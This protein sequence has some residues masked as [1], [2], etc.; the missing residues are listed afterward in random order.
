MCCG[1][2]F[3]IVNPLYVC[4]YTNKYYVLFAQSKNRFSQDEA[5]LIK[6]FWL[7]GVLGEL[8]SDF[9]KILTEFY[10]ISLK[11]CLSS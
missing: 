8:Q 4:I 5:H 9:C 11:I 10:Q 2:F 1:N 6:G 3:N 7:F